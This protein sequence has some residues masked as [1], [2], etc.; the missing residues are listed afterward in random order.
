MVRCSK[1]QF[2]HL[3]CRLRKEAETL[4]RAVGSYEK[5]IGSVLSMADLMEEAASVIEHL[6]KQPRGL[7]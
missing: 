4:R 5:L 6:Q 2:G 1:N 7:K 3:I